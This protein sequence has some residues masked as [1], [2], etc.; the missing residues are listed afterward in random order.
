MQ[1]QSRVRGVTLTELLVVISIM[2]IL[3]AIL[4]PALGA[5][6]HTSRVVAAA[7]SVATPLRQARF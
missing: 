3:M 5:F 2:I 7:D 4:V 1:S 6:T